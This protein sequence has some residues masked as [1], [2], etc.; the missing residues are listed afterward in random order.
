VYLV[1]AVSVRVNIVYKQVTKIAKDG[2]A[3]DRQLSKLKDSL[4]KIKDEVAFMRCGII[5]LIRNAG[6]LN[7]EFK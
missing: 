3:I 1:I 4:S 7:I 6:L 2:R 5:A